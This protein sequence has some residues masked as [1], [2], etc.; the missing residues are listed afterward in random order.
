MELG[1]VATKGPKT[2]SVSTLEGHWLT[3]PSFDIWYFASRLLKVA[4]AP[5][6][7]REHEGFLPD[8]F[9]RLY[10]PYFLSFHK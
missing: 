10:H 5:V 9:G 8:G 4:H 6:L 2:R 7:P 3:A 1:A